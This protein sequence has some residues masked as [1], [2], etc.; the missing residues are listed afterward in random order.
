MMVT[1]IMMMKHNLGIG[2][3]KDNSPCLFYLSV[4]EKKATG[5]LICKIINGAVQEV[6]HKEQSL[7]CIMRSKILTDAKI[8]IPYL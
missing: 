6:V 3:R 4:T 2:R 8:K 5:L 7:M 1:M